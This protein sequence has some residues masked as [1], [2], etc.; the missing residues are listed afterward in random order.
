MEP[1]SAERLE[2]LANIASL[3]FEEGLSQR[4]IA[5]RTGYSA[6]MI[7]RMLVE[8]RKHGLVE[9]RVHHI[10][11]RNTSLE[12]ELQERLNLKTVRVLGHEIRSY[13][14]MLSHLGRL[15][16]RLVDELVYDGITIGVSVGQGV[17]ETV[18]AVRP[19]SC[20]GAHVVQMVGSLRYPRPEIDGHEHAQHLARSLIGYYTPLPAPMF[21]E[22][23]TVLTSLLKDPQIK[24]IF[25]LFPRINLALMGIGTLDPE[26][27]EI[28]PAG[29]LTQE[30]LTI[31]EQYGA[32]GDVCGLFVDL[33]G[34][35]VDMPLE[36]RVVGIDRATLEAI[37]IKLGVAGGPSKVLPIIGACRAQLVDMLVTD[38]MAAKHILAILRRMAAGY[39]ENQEEEPQNG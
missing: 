24:S 28:I 17:Y 25:E 26:S 9:I 1:V 22:D 21:V 19:G 5:Q 23:E 39:E 35:I 29:Y 38:E 32:V 36:K 30:E 20:Y 4:E 18:Q 13:P 14:Q 8:A 12:E 37:P 3:Y 16:A 34:N 6:S 33:Y 27:A 31:L 7:S 11:R 15:A 10:L 2:L